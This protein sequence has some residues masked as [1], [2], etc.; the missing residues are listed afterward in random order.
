[1]RTCLCASAWG[2]RQELSPGVLGFNSNR[3]C[4]DRQGE[5]CA[6]VGVGV[7]GGTDA[8]CKMVVVA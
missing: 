5:T 7:G 1:M 6:Y 4:E 2:R 8:V 3:T